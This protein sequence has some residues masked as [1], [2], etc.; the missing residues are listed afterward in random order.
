MNDKTVTRPLEGIRVV[1]LEQYMAGPYCTMLLADA[2]AEVIKI[3]R[4]GSGDPR[5]V[6]PPFAEGNGKKKGAGFLGYNRNKKSLAL[7]LRAPEGQEV[8]RKLVQ[9]ADVV[10]ENLRPGSMSKQGLGFEDMRKTN[11]RLIWAVISGFGQ[12]EGYRGPYSDRPAFDIVAEAMGGIMHMVG[13]AD[14]PPSW[15]IYGMADIYSGQ[16]A[17]YGVM[18]ALFMRERTGEGQLVDSSMF[19]NMIALNEAQMALYSVAGQVNTRGKPKNAWPRDAYECSD[20]WLAVN[21]PDNIIWGRMAETIGRPDL[22]DD[23]RA[24]DGAARCRNIDFLQPV[25][26]D[27]FK[28]QTRDAAVNA[29]NA[30]GVPC[31]P[32]YDAEDIFNDPQVQARGVLV[33]IDDPDVGTLKFARTG[34]YLGAAPE[35]VTIPAPDLG[36]HTREVLEGMLDYSS[37]EVAALAEA[38]VVEVAEST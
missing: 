16:I 32:V 2:G 34:P 33:D 14:K 12:L 26:A 4:P 38:G 15:T 21:V 7:N 23:E 36:Q 19:D 27:W 25:L 35:I 3:E 5:R 9:T 13:F 22:K 18:Q 28:A 10:V 24:K 20:G 11:A 1:G 29:L 6:M 37:D 30:A 8:F 31:G 17:A